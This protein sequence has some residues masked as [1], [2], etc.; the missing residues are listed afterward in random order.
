MAEPAGLA[1][2]RN[3]VLLVLMSAAVPVSAQVDMDKILAR[4]VEEVEAF[5]GLAP[6]VLG[7]ETLKQRARKGSS[8]FRPRIGSGASNLSTPKYVTKEIVSEYGY[9]TFRE[10]PDSLHEFREVVSVDGRTVKPREKARQTL[11]EGMK[12]QDDRLKKR[13]LEEFERHGLTGAAS[14]FGQLILL[15]GQRRLGEYE[16]QFAGKG[17]IGPDEAIALSFRQTGDKGGVTIFENRKVVRRPLQGELWVREPDFLPLRI[18]LITV[19]DRDRYVIRD[20]ATVDYAMT[21]HGAVM[22]A[23]V[24]HR[25]YAADQLVVENLF[26]YGT[27]RKFSAEAEVKFTE[28]PEQPREE[29]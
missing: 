8:R 2:M 24:L 19:R 26:Q 11:A 23:S 13:L 12:S 1:T 17:R 29:K 22:P 6:D 16:F 25:Q 9:S 10:A 7:E 14:D 21:A 4:V 20:E 15:F 18:K 3:S 5:R 27:F 28:S